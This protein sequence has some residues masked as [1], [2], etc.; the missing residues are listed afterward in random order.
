MPLAQAIRAVLSQE[1]GIELAYLFGSH[2]RGQAASSSDVDVA[3]LTEPPLDLM[4]L[5]RL[6]ERLAQALGGAVD[7]VDLHHI[8]PLLAREI[9]RE[10]IAVHVADPA[11]KLA[12]ELDAI[13]RFEDTRWLRRQQQQLLR[14]RA[15]IGRQG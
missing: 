4:Q 6:Q 9:V 13:H 14:E 11:R 5:G 12:F 15:R 3:V 2:A 1:P 8:P 10:G 7:L